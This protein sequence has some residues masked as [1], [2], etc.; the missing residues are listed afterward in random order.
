MLQRGGALQ[1]INFAITF[2]VSIVQ[3]QTA[4][5]YFNSLAKK[6]AGSPWAHAKKIPLDTQGSIS[7]FITCF[8]TLAV[9]VLF[10]AVHA[11][12]YDVHTVSDI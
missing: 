5:K 11:G 10:V 2:L 12:N 3:T 1:F 7:A 4:F 9:M 6:H 8:C